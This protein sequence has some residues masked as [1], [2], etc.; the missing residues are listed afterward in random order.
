MVTFLRSHLIR[1]TKNLISI[2]RSNFY[3]KTI[4]MKVSNLLHSA[5]K[6]YKAKNYRQ[7]KTATVPKTIPFIL[8]VH[9]INAQYFHRKYKWANMAIHL[10]L[11]S[12]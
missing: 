8:T 11:H 1:C 2:C 6:N 7:T 9:I 12:E 5:R 4:S 3:Q 10:Y